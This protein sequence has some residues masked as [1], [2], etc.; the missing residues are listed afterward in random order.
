MIKVYVAGHTGM[1][2]SSIVRNLKKT[3]NFKIIKA[4]RKRLDLLNFNKVSNSLKCIKTLGLVP[5]FYAL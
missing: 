5:F 3:R 4:E 2:G 1:V